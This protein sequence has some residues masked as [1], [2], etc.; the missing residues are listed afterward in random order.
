[1]HG[2]ATRCLFPQVLQR[3]RP[4]AAV[5]LDSDVSAS[6]PQLVTV[7][8]LISIAGLLVVI[9]LALALADPFA[10]VFVGGLDK[11]I[12]LAVPAL[13]LAAA[14]MVGSLC[15]FW[16]WENHTEASDSDEGARRES[17][18]V[19][20]GDIFVN[21]V[22]EHLETEQLLPHQRRQP[23]E[24]TQAKSRPHSQ[25]RSPRRVLRSSP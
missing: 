22:C 7:V 5:A 12:P 19:E 25:Q 18:D 10:V 15:L 11:R 9:S 2:L 8:G 17:E 1:M 4:A 3:Q 20:S 14:F 23:A 24:Q 6:L 21:E 16:S 13:A